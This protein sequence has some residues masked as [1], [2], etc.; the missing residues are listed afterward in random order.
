MIGRTWILAA[1]VAPACVYAGGTA[2]LT[3][4]DEQGKQLTATVEFVGT[5]RLRVTSPN[6]PGAY[7]IARDGKVYNIAKIQGRTVVMEAKD[8]MRMAGNMMPSPTAA[9]EQVNSVV[10]L[11]P[12]SAKE[13]VAGINGTVYKLTYEDGQ[14]RTRTE[15]LVLAKDARATEF[16]SAAVHFGK[17]LAAA[18]GAIIPPGADDLVARIQRDGLGLLRFGNR[19][20]INS[21]NGTTP[22][23]TRFDLP[24]GSFQMPDLG[25]LFPGLGGAR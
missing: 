11:T 16:T 19:I 3:A 18:S 5:S 6:Q 23:A 1:L 13:T 17:T 25:G 9:I 2:N 21:L 12:T 4:R 14:R 22:A 10:S 8:L 15:D 20:E 7:M 24:A